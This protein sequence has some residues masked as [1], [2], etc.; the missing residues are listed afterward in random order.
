MQRIVEFSCHG[1]RMHLAKCF[2][3]ASSKDANKTL[4]GQFLTF[5]APLLKICIQSSLLDLEFHFFALR[6]KNQF[7]KFKEVSR[8]RFFRDPGYTS[9]PFQ[10]LHMRRKGKNFRSGAV[11]VSALLQK[12]LFRFGGSNR[13]TTL[14]SHGCELLS[15]R[16]ARF[17]TGA[18]DF[19]GPISS[20]CH[21]HRYKA[22]AE[23]PCYGSVHLT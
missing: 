12:C 9:D 7:L 11:K 15:T 6:T 18:P 20:A 3:G 4:R 22:S 23:V 2:E 10:P 1:V 8:T 5:R 21:C 13:P 14:C 16:K 17:R 19:C